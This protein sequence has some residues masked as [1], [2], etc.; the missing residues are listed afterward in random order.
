MPLKSFPY[1]ASEIRH[2]KMLSAFLSLLLVPARGHSAGRSAHASLRSRGATLQGRS[3]RQSAS[4]S[5]SEEEKEQPS[6]DQ[7]AEHLARTKKAIAVAGA[8]GRIGS[9]VVERLVQ[10]GHLVKA[11]VRSSSKADGVLPSLEGIERVQVDFSTASD[12]E[13][14]DALS[15]TDAVIWCASGFTDDGASLDLQGMQQLPKL[16]EEEDSAATP[17]V[18]MLSSAG[19][20]RTVWSD[21]KKERLVG[22]ADIPIIRLNPGG[23]LDCKRQAEELLRQSGVPY[24]IV[25]P[26]GLK[27][28]GSWPQ[29]RPILSQGDV[30]V[31]RANGADVADV[32]CSVVD[33]P[34]AT[35]K[36]FEMFTLQGYPP[37]RE[38][39]GNVLA[40]LRSDNA[41]AGPD[42][43]ERAVD[44]AYASL[45]QL[46]P[47]EEQDA[48][49][50]EMGR[51]YE[52]V[53]SGDVAARERGAAP[54]AREVELASSVVTPTGGKRQAVK[55]F[56]KNLLP[57]K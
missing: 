6:K 38:G 7:G 12:T 4:I 14:R 20:T 26:T 40:R 24:C 57:A 22:A 48:T 55:K 13:V 5:M 25:R 32:L 19:V 45:Q 46:L 11:L 35:G 52:Q 21:E 44:V 28:D 8:S 15:G 30:A 34:S 33:E 42:L 39:L 18:V 53:D 54:T 50:L 23:I 16:F 29:G 37:A 49:K 17:R 10:N 36:T 43:D 31:G 27:L 2:E 3:A 56:L 1:A 47:G 41:P 51:T 9:L